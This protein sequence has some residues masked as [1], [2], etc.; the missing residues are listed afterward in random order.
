MAKRKNSGDYL[1][2]LR[3]DQEKML[4]P[5]RYYSENIPTPLDEARGN[6]T[7][8]GVFYI[9]AGS[10]IVFFGLIY[11]L[12]N[13]IV[14]GPENTYVDGVRVS[15]SFDFRGFDFSFE[16]VVLPLMILGT[17]GSFFIFIGSRHIAKGRKKKKAQELANRNRRKTRKK[18]K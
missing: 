3:D 1:D 9:V 12:S 6:P 10:I 15:S 18:R 8:L 2:K 4:N 5:Y 13:L 17:F 16:G 7:P 11:A 14:G